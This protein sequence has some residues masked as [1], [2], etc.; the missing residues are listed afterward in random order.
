MGRGRGGPADFDWYNLTRQR[1]LRSICP[2]VPGH[3]DPYRLG[4]LQEQDMD[5]EKPPPLKET[6][7]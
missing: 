4:F 2:K 6:A 3:G 5:I 7:T 1:P